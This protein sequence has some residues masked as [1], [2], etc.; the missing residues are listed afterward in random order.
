MLMTLQEAKLQ[1]Q[2]NS[3]KIP[4]PQAQGSVAR[5]ETQG[6]MH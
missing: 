5:Q 4:L 2:K 3:G 6:W 1:I